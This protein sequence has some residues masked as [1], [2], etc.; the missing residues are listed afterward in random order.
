MALHKE[1]LEK[2]IKTGLENALC[3]NT[4]HMNSTVASI[5]NICG[6]PGGND[7]II[8]DNTEA[9]IDVLKSQLI[10]AMAQEIAGA[11]DEYI[12]GL[13]GKCTF[14]IT[15]HGSPSTHIGNFTMKMKFQGNGLGGE[16]KSII[17]NTLWFK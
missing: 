17:P 2:N 12:K 8:K 14:L 3:S 7:E 13:E 15:T 4:D 16:V 5:L 1:D 11:V 6:V 10:P 9:I